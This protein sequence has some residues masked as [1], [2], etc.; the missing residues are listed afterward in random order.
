M[1][2]RTSISTYHQIK[3]EGLL[4][5][6]RLI[7]YQDVFEHGPCTMMDTNLRLNKGTYSNGSFTSR[8]SELRRL[9]VIVEVGT[10]KCKHTGRTAIIWDVTESL[11]KKLEKK[12]TNK[13]KIKR[14]E[15]EL[16]EL[17]AGLCEKCR[18]MEL[19]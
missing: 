15:M 10:T 14:L 13:Q 6:L 7:V 8:F 3:N 9:G 2:R 18:N 17:R 5:R 11:P 19:F 12:E 16:F 1:V 4:S